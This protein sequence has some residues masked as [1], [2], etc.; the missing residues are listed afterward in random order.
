MWRANLLPV[1]IVPAA[2][3]A[4]H[5]TMFALDSPCAIIVHV[6]KVRYLR[7]VAGT[8]LERIHP[9]WWKGGIESTLRHSWIIW[10]WDGTVIL[11]S[12]S[13]IDFF[14]TVPVRFGKLNLLVRLLD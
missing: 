2:A 5:P 3:Y 11:F 9:N 8:S 12:D 10:W 1:E 6:T 4:G 13:L 7:K 14:N